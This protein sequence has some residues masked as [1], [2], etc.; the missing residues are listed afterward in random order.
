MQPLQRY[1]DSSK[2]LIYSFTNCI[3]TIIIQS[4]KIHILQ[5][6]TARV[7]LVPNNIKTRNVT[8]ELILLQNEDNSIQITGQV[9]GLTEGLH[10]IHVHEK[11]DLRDGCMSTG[12]HFNPENVNYYLTIMPR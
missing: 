2:F 11:G 4:Y 10:G 3:I 12:P 8:G 9:H 6:K 1:V 7:H 5:Q